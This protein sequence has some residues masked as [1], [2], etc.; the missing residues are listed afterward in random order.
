MAEGHE[1]RVRQMMDAFKQDAPAGPL[2]P[3]LKDRIL[4]ASMLLEE[5]FEYITA[6]GLHVA[7]CLD[8]LDADTGKV[9][10]EDLDVVASDGKEPDLVGMIDGL[11]DVSVVCTGGFVSAGV[12]AEPVL[13]LVDENNLLKAAN[14]SFNSLG[15]FCK[16]TGHVPPDIAGELQRQIDGCTWHTAMYPQVCTCETVYSVVEDETA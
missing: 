15:K 2:M 9:Y 7:V 1:Q 6:A 16:A 13:K 11:A 8:G 10:F 3:K 5:V 12:H 4:R 14:G